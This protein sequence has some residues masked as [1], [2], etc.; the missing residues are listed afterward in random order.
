MPSQGLTVRTLLDLAPSIALPRHPL[1]LYGITLHA[2][3]PSKGDRETTLEHFR[4]RDELQR[5]I[6][7]LLRDTGH[8]VT[9]CQRNLQGTVV[10]IYR[11]PGISASFS[12][13]ITCG[14]VWICPTCALPITE[15]R[16]LELQLGIRRH[17]QE[18]GATYLMTLTV[19]HTRHIPLEV[20]DPLF[21]KALTAFK[22]CRTYKRLLGTP[23][24][25]GKYHRIGSVRSLEITF[26][27]NGPHPHTH[28]LIFAD[29]HLL[30]DYYALE[31]L[32]QEWTRIVLKVGL[33]ASN[34]RADLLEHGFDLCGGDYAAEYVAKYGRQPLLEGWGITDELTRSHSKTGTRVGHLTPFALA[35]AYQQGDE[36][37]GELFREYA[38]IYA[39]KRMLS[40]SPGLKRRFGME[41]PTDAELA[42]RPLVDEEPVC[43]LD[44]D[45]W[46]MVLSRNARGELK[47]WA[48]MEG[49][50]GVRAFLD[51]LSTRPRTHQHQFDAQT[52]WRPHELR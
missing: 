33:G 11:R 28:D 43:Q 18:G 32:R 1:G 25:P 2:A 20:L 45:Q 37:A 9:T 52:R 8:S 5:V 29:P 23:E 14:C 35:R 34:E 6:Q 42:Q 10:N 50:P 41:D 39:G 7:G 27:P 26:G 36:E 48:A 47:W 49:E 24:K 4:A 16:R 38:R 30:E 40:W 44:V 15:R 13:V 22:N 46:R 31:E 51:E 12:G 3:K 21:T 17:A 19:P